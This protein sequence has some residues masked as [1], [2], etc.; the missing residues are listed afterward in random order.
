M[1]GWELAWYWDGTWV[2]E[3]ASNI[4]DV[5]FSRAT[6]EA[7]FCLASTAAECQGPDSTSPPPTADFC[8]SYWVK[9]DSKPLSVASTVEE[10]L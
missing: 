6:G 5:W 3:S 9:C 8:I 7:S 1:H 10:D 4:V 2:E